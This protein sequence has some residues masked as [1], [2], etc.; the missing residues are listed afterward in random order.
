M[1]NHVKTDAVKA[2]AAKAAVQKGVVRIGTSGIVLPG[3]KASFPEEFQSGSRLHYYA[4]LFN[5]LEVNSS[6]YKIPLS[7]TFER[8]TTEVPDDFQFTVKL[9]QG[10]T[11]VKRLAYIPENID[12]FMHAVNHLGNKKGCLLIQFPASISFQYAN[13]VSDI[14][15]RINQSNKDGLWKLAI[16]F[17][18]SSWYQDDVYRMLQ[19]HNTSLVLHDMPTSKTPDNHP[20]ANFVY[21]RFHGPTGKYDGAYSEKVIQHHAD[22]VKQ[23]V[24]EG[25]DVYIY[26]N[27]TIGGALQNAKLFQ[28]LTINN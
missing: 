26:F 17:R 23:L 19:K 4:S 3:T 1:T 25:K 5:T 13:S 24:N 18:H 21:L 28:Q 11:H 6:F 16:E 20:T 12:I 2:H 7:K 8:W 27:N 15:E 14:L 9:W 10:I 22:I